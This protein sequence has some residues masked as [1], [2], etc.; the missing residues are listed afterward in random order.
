M[1][2]RG[3]HLPDA[4]LGLATIVVL[5]VG[6]EASV[7]AGAVNAAIVPPPTVVVQKLASI[8]SAGAFLEPLG[9]TL[10]LLFVSYATGCGLTLPV[11]S[12]ASMT[13]P[14]DG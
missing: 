4:L 10:Y 2:T 9:Q 8:L 11:N 6:L 3:A 1:K 5:L 13:A 7:R 12:S 14:L